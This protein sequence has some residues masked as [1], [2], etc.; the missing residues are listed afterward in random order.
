MNKLTLLFVTAFSLG[1]AACGGLNTTTEDYRAKQ[2]REDLAK[3]QAVAGTYSGYLLDSNRENIGFL[4]V[5]LRA[6]TIVDKGDTRSQERAV[7]QSELTMRA[8]KIYTASMPDGSYDSDSKT[9]RSTLT[10]GR[11]APTSASSSGASASSSS[12]LSYTLQLSSQVEADQL[13]GKL[14]VEGFS[15]TEGNFRLTKDA[16]IPA[17]ADIDVPQNAYRSLQFGQEASYT[18]AVLWPELSP[19]PFT[20]T[21]KLA[22]NTLQ[23]DQEFVEFLSTRRTIRAEVAFF[24][25]DASGSRSIEST[26]GFA[27][28]VW[29]I[30]AQTLAGNAENGLGVKTGYLLS[31][32]GDIQSGWNC[33][34]RIQ[35]RQDV[36]FTLKP[37]N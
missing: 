16:A 25:L 34:I 26:L 36:T 11:S 10:I 23:T 28:T 27:N 30:Q 24:Q 6:T 33:V 1:L 32:R 2:L 20:V 19:K 35:N 37:A 31:C 29:D 7:L 9:L 13:V 18:G 17:A 15:S 3:L 14:T 4:T 21:M 12:G 8:G 5:K 22:S